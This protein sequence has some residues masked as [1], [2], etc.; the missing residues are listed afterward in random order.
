MRSDVKGNLHG[1]VAL[2]VPD[3][4]RLSDNSV[5]WTVNV[6]RF[7]EIS[8]ELP[9]SGRNVPHGSDFTIYPN[10]VKVVFRCVFPI[11]ADPSATASCYVDYQEFAKSLTGRCIIRWDNL[12]QGVISWSAQPEVAEC[13]EKL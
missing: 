7:V 8:A 10:K 11:I 6:S 9:V 5:S 2:E 12:P 1:E 4:L 13:V 3:R